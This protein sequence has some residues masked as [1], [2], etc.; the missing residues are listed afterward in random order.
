MYAELGIFGFHM[1][2]TNVNDVSLCDTVT[3]GFFSV[4]SVQHKILANVHPSERMS[5]N[6]CSITDTSVENRYKMSKNTV[7]VLTLQNLF[8][9]GHTTLQCL[10]AVLLNFSS[11]LP[12]EQVCQ[13][14]HRRWRT[15]KKI[16]FS[17]PTIPSSSSTSSSIFYWEYS[18]WFR[19]VVRCRSF[20][21]F[22]EYG[23][24]IAGMGS[25]RGGRRLIAS[26]MADAQCHI[27]YARRRRFLCVSGNG[28]TSEYLSYVFLAVNSRKTAIIALTN[29]RFLS[30]PNYG[31]DTYSYIFVICRLLVLYSHNFF[32]FSIC[33]PLQTSKLHMRSIKVIYY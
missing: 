18:N 16:L 8:S 12:H 22:I 29:R 23:S 5:N 33:F 26:N 11:Q 13:L 9:P 24:R 27:V 1:E 4:C 21:I 31:N 15:H 2:L 25:F 7:F 10:R 14:V 6:E 17:N 32:H 20:H 28:G 30:V 3:E 19:I